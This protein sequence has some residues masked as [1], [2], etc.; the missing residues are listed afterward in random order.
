MFISSIFLKQNFFKK[1]QIYILSFEVLDLYDY[2]LWKLFV[3]KKWLFSFMWFSFLKIVC[4]RKTI[5]FSFL[6]F[7]NSSFLSYSINFVWLF[8]LFCSQF[9]FFVFILVFVLV[10]VFFL[11]FVFVFDQ[12]LNQLDV[13]RWLFQKRLFFCTTAIFVLI[14]SKKKGSFKK[15]FFYCIISICSLR[16]WQ[17]NY[18][19]LFALSSEFDP[20]HLFF[21]FFSF[22]RT[23]FSNNRKFQFIDCLH[24]QSLLILLY[25]ISCH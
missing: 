9:C 6:S 16:L 14:H 1:I 12:K 18:N 24:N 11:V 2:N 13:Q 25:W 22:S 15:K 5:V 7:L 19:K 20:M 4:F 17:F 10:F 8:S 3:F 23:L 21:Y